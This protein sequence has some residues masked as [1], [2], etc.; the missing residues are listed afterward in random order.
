MPGP[1]LHM[2]AVVT[3]AHGGQAVPTVPSTAVFVSG[4]PIAT[5]A[6]PYAIAGCPFVPPARQRPVRD[7][8]V[9]R[10]RHPGL[11][12]RAAS[13]D[14]ERRLDLHADR[15]AAAPGLGPDAGDRD[16]SAGDVPVN[17]NFPFEFDGRGRTRDPQNA[18]V[19]QLIEQVLF[20]SPG[21]RLNMPDF[22]SGLLQLPFA[23]DSAETRGGDAVRRAGLPA[24]VAQ[25]LHRR[26]VRRRIGARRAAQREGHVFARQPGRHPGADVRLRG[27]RMIYACCEERRRAAV[28]GNPT[29][30]G[31]DYLEVL[32]HDAPPGSPRQQSL[33]LHCLKAAPTTLQPANVLITGGESIIGISAVWI[34]PATNLPPAAGPAEVA[35]FGSLPDAANVLVVRTNKYGDFSPY[36]LRLVNDAEQASEDPLEVTESLDGFDPQLTEV[37]F[38]FK[39]E[40]GP[41]FDCA[42]A[43]PECPP[44]LADPAADQL[45]REGL[46]IVQ[47]RPARP[48][49]AAPAGLAGNE[50]GGHRRC[51]R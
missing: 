13:R 46:R 6:A 40:C 29:L 34:A 39:V 33:L 18:Y 37:R 36:T 42:P 21:E 3:C 51:D 30:N 1:I 48:S 12:A 5:I 25:R 16:M 11:L 20:T 44:D 17:V 35:Y 26:A 28:L 4:M 27:H 32:D 47:D 31:I 7:R 45:P 9:A 49:E 22:G 10:R 24:E 23:P 41:D 15:N 2:G 38:N 19:R 8:A 43:T 50:R 14:H